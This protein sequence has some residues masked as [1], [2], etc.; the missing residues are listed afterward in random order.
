MKFYEIL[1]VKS[2]VGS[3]KNNLVGKF[4]TFVGATNNFKI[5]AYIMSGNTFLKVD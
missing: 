3:D 5:S 2:P 4:S 1:F